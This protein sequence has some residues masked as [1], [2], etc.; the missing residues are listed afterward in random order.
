MFSFQD[1]NQRFVATKH[2]SG[3]AS[4]RET[5][6]KDLAQAYDAFMELLANLQEGKKVK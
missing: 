3:A 1:A 6:L 5:M 2:D 4:Q